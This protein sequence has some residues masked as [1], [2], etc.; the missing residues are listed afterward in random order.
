MAKPIVVNLKGMETIFS[1]VKLDRS[2]LYGRKRRFLLGPDNK[3]CQRAQLIEDG[4]LLLRS[5]MSAQGYFDND[6]NVVNKSEFVG[7]GA[8]GSLI[9]RHPSTLGLAEPSNAIAY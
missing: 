2:K 6:G 5:G 4:S 7:L 1:F 8:D 3:P 9:E